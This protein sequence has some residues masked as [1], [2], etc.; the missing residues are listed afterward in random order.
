MRVAELKIDGFRGFDTVHIRPRGDVA[1]IGEPRSGR[2]NVVA[3]LERVLHPDG[4]R[5]HVRE[6]DFHGGDLDRVLTI[7][8]T[9]TALGSALQ[10]RFVRRLEAWDQS[11]REIV[12][13]SDEPLTGEELDAALRL[14]WTCTWNRDE[15]RADHRVEYVKRLGGASEHADRVSR[16]DR[17]ALPFRSIRQREPLDLPGG[18]Q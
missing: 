7:E 8:V 4:T 6:W 5:W 18:G 11:V 9:L 17:E 1:L 15:E 16:D 12:A 3:A 10:Q 2:S 13:T 14:R